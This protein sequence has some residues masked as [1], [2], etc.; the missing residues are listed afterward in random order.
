MISK[1]K[2][3][4]EFNA[5]EIEN[6]VDKQNIQFRKDKQEGGKTGNVTVRDPT[7]ALPK[8]R[9]RT[10]TDQVTANTED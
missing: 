5:L 1:L 8:S 9:S 10:D 3:S 7:P 2:N 4:K 6:I